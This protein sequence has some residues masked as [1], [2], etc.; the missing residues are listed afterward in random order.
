[1]TASKTAV[2]SLSSPPAALARSPSVLPC[3]TFLSPNA[4]SLVVWSALN[5]AV[6]AAE[7]LVRREAASAGCSKRER[8]CE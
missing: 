4:C 7:N 8:C 6:L 3:A 1:M 2:V 5:A